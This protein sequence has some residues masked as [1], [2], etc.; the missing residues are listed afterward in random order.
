MCTLGNCHFHV[1][2]AVKW[3]H[4]DIIVTIPSKLQL[5]KKWALFEYG[6][7]VEFNC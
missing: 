6:K 4:N 3:T 1:Q 5:V 2:L 7:G